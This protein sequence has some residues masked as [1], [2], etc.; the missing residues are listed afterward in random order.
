MQIER[1][2]DSAI[3]KPELTM[4]EA[5]SWIVQGIK[6]KVK[7]VCVRPC[8][9][10]LAK[11]LTTGTDTEVCVV[12]DFPHGVS[13]LAAKEVLAETYIAKGV[14]EIDMVLNY[15]YI[16]SGAWDKVQAEVEAVVKKAHASNVLVKCIFET[17][18][19]TLEEIAKT[20][21]T[22]IAA[23]ADFV[24]TSTGFYGDGATIE[25]VQTMLDASKGEIKVKPSGGIRNY[26]KAKMFV[27]M[28]ADRLG[29]GFNSVVPIV[30]RQKENDTCGY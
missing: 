25:A 17:S 9:I 29:V 21:E 15:G 2:L 13:G 7:T 26:E 1:Y 16:R 20:T 24:K 5:E 23:K 4:A 14:D 12:L 11:K 19:L 10:E 8:D 22:C 6:Y 30:E 28:G 27:D 3:L 18:Q